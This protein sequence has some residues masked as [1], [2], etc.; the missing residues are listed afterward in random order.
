MFGGRNRASVK[1]GKK[2]TAVCPKP[3]RAVRTRH[4]R[5]S[6]FVSNTHSTRVPSR[7]RGN[8]TNHENAKLFTIEQFFQ[9]LEW[10]DSS[11][12]EHGI[13]EWL[14]DSGSGERKSMRSGA[15]EQRFSR[16]V[17]GLR[18]G[19]LNRRERPMLARKAGD[20]S[21]RDTSGCHL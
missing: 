21:I 8:D 11:F 10:L 12:Q 19:E 1:A 14:R 18:K 4:P 3:D 9:S 17:E 6:G 20:V 2:A 13:K 7:I 16:F 5:F 15:T